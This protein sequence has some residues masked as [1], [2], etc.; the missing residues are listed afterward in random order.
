M[1]LLVILQ[2]N[3]SVLLL[4]AK[5]DIKKAFETGAFNNCGKYVEDVTKILDKMLDT[6]V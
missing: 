6:D 3:F 2:H 1:L 4:I 5:E